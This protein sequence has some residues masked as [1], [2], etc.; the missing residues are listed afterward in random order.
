[1]DFKNI[2]NSCYVLSQKDE[3]SQIS[4]KKAKK[5]LRNLFSNE[6]L[7]RHEYI[8]FNFYDLEIINNFKTYVNSAQEVKLPMIPGI[9]AAGEVVG[10]GSAVKDFKPGEK[11]IYITSKAGGGYAQYN[12]LS[13]NLL[14]KAPEKIDLSVA[15]V[16]ASR[17][18][19]AHNLL[20][21][22]YMADK[23]SAILLTNPNGALGHIVAQMTSFLE[24][25]LISIVEGDLNSSKKD[26][27][28]SLGY[29]DLILDL[30]NEKL[31]DKI[32]EFTDGF[33]VNLLIDTIGSNRLK[34]LLEC[35]SYCGLFVSL[36]CNS[37]KNLQ[38]DLV[39]M[40]RRSI[41]L[42]RPS[43]FDYKQNIN[44]LRLSALEVF[45]LYNLGK[46]NP[47]IDQIFNFEQIFDVL[48][49]AKNR[50]L[51]FANLIKL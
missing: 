31:I 12:I 15:L 27:L 11:V 28:K 24:A 17:G 45:N 29:Y 4:L 14:I 1:M 37:G 13:Q 48:E 23:N 35:I 19:M 25:K 10:V 9:E 49:K 41:F 50:N 20:R 30:E 46:L 34:K 44:E 38:V 21:K 22:V 42:T 26:L 2:I 5:N 6:V 18:V 51:K 7:I 16:L 3:H 47:I 40:M 36:G 33:G 39:Q 32:M 43:L 8:G